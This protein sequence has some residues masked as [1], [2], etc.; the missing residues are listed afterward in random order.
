MNLPK[1]SQTSQVTR[2]ECI[3]KLD[4]HAGDFVHVKLGGD[5]GPG[6]GVWIPSTADLYEAFTAWRPLMEKRG[7]D[8]IVTHHLVSTALIEP[9][10]NLS[11]WPPKLFADKLKNDQ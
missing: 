11:T 9:K 7:V 4:L 1:P 10:I 5:L 3:G 6:N 8:M 2:V